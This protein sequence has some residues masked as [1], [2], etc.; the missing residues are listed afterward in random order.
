MTLLALDRYMDTGA[1]RVG[2]DPFAGYERAVAPSSCGI[3][4]NV[5]MNQDGGY[6]IKELTKGGGAEVGGLRVGDV[7]HAVAGHVMKGE[8][9]DGLVQRVMGLE[10]SVVN[11]TVARGDGSG[12]SVLET[13]QVVRSGVSGAG[14]TTGE[15]PDTLLGGG[16]RRPGMGHGGDVM[17]SGRSE[18]WTIHGGGGKPREEQ[19]PLRNPFEITDEDLKGFGLRKGSIEMGNLSDEEEDMV[20]DGA[21][22]ED[23]DSAAAKWGWD[24]LEKGPDEWVQDPEKESMFDGHVIAPRE[25]KTV[26]PR[27]MGVT[28]DEGDYQ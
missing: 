25:Q 3:G 14:E 9:T 12:F 4:A 20:A 22:D 24:E 17:T 10:G 6:Y 18:P 5:G 11:V 7:I 15:R 27:A 16:D 21:E 28:G 1:V 23:H 26:Q 19:Q 2:S 8:R 13:L